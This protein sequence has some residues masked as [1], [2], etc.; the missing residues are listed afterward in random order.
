MAQRVEI[1]LEDDIDGSAADETVEFRLDG[2]GYE[3]DL[4]STTQPSCAVLWSAG[5]VLPVVSAVPGDE[6]TSASRQQRHQTG[7]RAGPT[8]PSWR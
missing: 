2:A 1:V 8:R 6:A 5:L 7:S 3:I 4:T